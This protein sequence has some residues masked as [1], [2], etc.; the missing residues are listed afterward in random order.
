MYVQISQKY[1]AG[2]TRLRKH[3][4]RDYLCNIMK[5]KINGKRV[6][7]GNVILYPR[8]LRDQS[9]QERERES[10]GH[11]SNRA[12]WIGSLQAF[13]LSQEAELSSRTL[14]TFPLEESQPPGGL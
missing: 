5:W 11:G 12:S 7:N 8:S 2:S 13:I 10:T 6:E 3:R 14:S 4:F 9:A 1:P